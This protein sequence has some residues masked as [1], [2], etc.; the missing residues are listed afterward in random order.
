MHQLFEGIVENQNI[1]LCNRG[2]SRSTPLLHLT[3]VA[4][5]SNIIL[6]L[7]STRRD[8]LHQSHFCSYGK[9]TYMVIVLDALLGSLMTDGFCLRDY[10]TY[11]ILQQIISLL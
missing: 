3:C 10:T 8:I 9:H 2:I 5:S 7:G 6:N 11:H 4:G 1:L